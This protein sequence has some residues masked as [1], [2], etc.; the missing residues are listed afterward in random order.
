MRIDFPDNKRVP[1]EPEEAKDIYE[2]E[3]DDY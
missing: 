2:V 1:Y 3:K